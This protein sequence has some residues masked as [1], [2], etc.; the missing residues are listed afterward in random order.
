MGEEAPQIASE[1]GRQVLRQTRPRWRRG[2]V[3]RGTIGGSA[4]RTTALGRGQRREDQRGGIRP[5]FR[6]ETARQG[7]QAR[8]PSAGQTPGGAEPKGR[9]AR[10][11][12]R[13]PPWQ[14]ASGVT[15][16]V[17]RSGPR[18]RRADWAV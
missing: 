16:L 8:H 3:R 9:A 17:P 15:R 1:R 12:D 18:W 13:V 11:A 5:L 14:N 10:Q 7:E 2:A 4:R 6:V